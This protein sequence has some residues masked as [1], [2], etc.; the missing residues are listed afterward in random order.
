MINMRQ[1]FS[2]A[3]PCFLVEMNTTDTRSHSWSLSRG[4]A[5][6]RESSKS[7]EVASLISGGLFST[8]EMWIDAI[9]GN[10][11][12]VFIE[13]EERKKVR[14]SICG[15]YWWSEHSGR[16]NV[17][18]LTKKIFYLFTL[19]NDSLYCSLNPISSCNSSPFSVAMLQQNGDEILIYFSCFSP[20]TIT[21]VIYIGNTYRRRRATHNS[22]YTEQRQMEL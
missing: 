15:K 19:G 13:E 12:Q 1:Y 9:K 4:F 3:R 5:V 10:N 8:R 14:S 11:A 6:N 7:P 21:H 16:L 17:L 18:H 22:F 20:R 2:F